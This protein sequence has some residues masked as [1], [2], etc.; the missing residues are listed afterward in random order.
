M[1]NLW[2]TL[3]KLIV[4]SCRHGW[5]R[6]L[7][8]SFWL[9]CAVLPKW[10]R[11]FYPTPKPSPCISCRSGWRSGV[12]RRKSYFTVVVVRVQHKFVLFCSNRALARCSIYALVLLTGIARDMRLKRPGLPVWPVDQALSGCELNRAIQRFGLRLTGS[13]PIKAAH[14]LEPIDG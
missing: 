9:M 11:G 5:R 3:K 8:V 10:R 2:L 4:T 1:V 14:L 13:Y 7:R 12:T 6:T